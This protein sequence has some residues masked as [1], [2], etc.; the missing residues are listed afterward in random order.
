MKPINFQN[1]KNSVK[2]PVSFLILKPLH[3]VYYV[4]K[5]ARREMIRICGY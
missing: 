3:N 4:A 2:N 5:S 1:S